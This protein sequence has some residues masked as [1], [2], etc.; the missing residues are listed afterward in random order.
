M[1]RL[2]YNVS[3]IHAYELSAVRL[4]S[5]QEKNKKNLDEI[6][7]LRQ[8][9]LNKDQDYQKAKQALVQPTEDLAALRSDFD[10]LTREHENV[11]RRSAACV[12]LLNIDN[13]RK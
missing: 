5:E 4:I 11:K 12:A 3:S 7:V 8:E 2:S 13:T 9:L 1:S 10:A 6:N